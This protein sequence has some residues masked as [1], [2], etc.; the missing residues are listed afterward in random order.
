MATAAFGIGLLAV[1]VLYPLT[2][3]A[4]LWGLATLERWMVTPTEHAAEV[5]RLLAVEDPETIE[6]E[7]AHMLRGDADRREQRVQAT[8]MRRA[9]RLRTS[10]A[11]RRLLQRRG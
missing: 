1:L 3:L 11:L 10:L 8:A 5:A 4:A 6:S 9:K 7:V 2:L